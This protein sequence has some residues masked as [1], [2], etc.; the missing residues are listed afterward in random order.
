MPAKIL[1]RIIRADQTVA[2]KIL[3]EKLGEEA[4][5]VYDHEIWN[6]IRDGRPK[7]SLAEMDLVKDLPAVRLK[8]IAELKRTLPGSEIVDAE[9]YVD[10]KANRRGS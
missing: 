1:H 8:K 9:D 10:R 6:M 4:W 7:F 5:V 2:L 3:S